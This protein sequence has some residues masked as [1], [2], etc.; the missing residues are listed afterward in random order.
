[1]RHGGRMLHQRLHAAQG[2]RQLPYAAVLKHVNDRVD[3]VKLT[4]FEF[5]IG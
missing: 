1:V 2:D 4:L 5:K 3:G